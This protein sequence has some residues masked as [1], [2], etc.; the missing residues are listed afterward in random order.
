MDGWMDGLIGIRGTPRDGF[1]DGLIRI[2]G[3]PGDG[4]TDRFIDSID[5]CSWEPLI[6]IRGTPRDGSIDSIGWCFVGPQGMDG[7]I[8]GRTLRELGV[9]ARVDGEL[10]T[11]ARRAVAKYLRHWHEDMRFRDSVEKGMKCLK[12]DR[13]L[14]NFGDDQGND[15][16]KNAKKDVFGVDLSP[17][18][19]FISCMRRII[20]ITHQRYLHQVRCG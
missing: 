9:S 7:W 3:T 8:D 13:R 15:W 2:R 12:A 16:K 11:G 1:M 14:G 18:L 17:R 6:G 20:T 4:S 19:A 5:R 10:R